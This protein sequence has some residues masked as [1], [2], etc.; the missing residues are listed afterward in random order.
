MSNPSFSTNHSLPI[1]VCASGYFSAI[2]RGHIEYLAKSKALGDFLV[3]IV[4]ND[5]QTRLKH[6]EVFK[7]IEDRLEVVRALRC[8]DL[9]IVSADTD[10]TVC[11]TLEILRPHIF[12]NGGDQTNTHVPEKEV[13][14]KYGIKMV[15]G[16]GGKIQSSSWILSDYC[17]KK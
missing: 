2:H 7:K 4:N 1:I 6:G 14:E 17:S 8:V 9:A 15:D 5:E 3:V 13:C 16:L 12:T 11:K 10:R